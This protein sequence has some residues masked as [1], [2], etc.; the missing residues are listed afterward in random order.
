MSKSF[1]FIYQFLLNFYF[2]AEAI[3]TRNRNPI[4]AKKHPS[5]PQPSDESEFPL[6]SRMIII[7][8]NKKTITVITVL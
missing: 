2:E 3:I 5:H 6:L 1:C 4:I 7:I 8:I